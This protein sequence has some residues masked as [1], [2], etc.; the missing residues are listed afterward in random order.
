MKKFVIDKQALRM[1][2]ADISTF[3]QMGFLLATPPVV[4]CLI[5]H[6]CIKRFSFPSWTM[7]IAIFVGLLCG[8]TTA[9]RFLLGF[10]EKKTKESDKK[11]I[12]T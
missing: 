10:L 6:F 5:I 11:V 3:G 8:I 12:K 9:A 7:I 4:L 2:L 1:A